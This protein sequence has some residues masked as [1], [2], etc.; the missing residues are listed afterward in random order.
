[1][2]ASGAEYAPI[3]ANILNLDLLPFNFDVGNL[4][5]NPEPTP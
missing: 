4:P 1:M 2:C 5:L 3:L